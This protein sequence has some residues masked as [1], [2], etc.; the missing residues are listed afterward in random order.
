MLID[1]ESKPEK[2]VE[3]EFMVENSYKMLQLRNAGIEFEMAKAFATYWH[4]VEIT[5]LDKL[6]RATLQATRFVLKDREMKS[7]S[8][9]KAL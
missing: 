9:L 8:F 5:P 4:E 1:L 3:E 2:T 7:A 6:S